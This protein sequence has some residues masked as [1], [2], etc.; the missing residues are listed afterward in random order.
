MPRLRSS[1]P[2]DRYG[3]RR[4]HRQGLGRPDRQAGTISPG[5]H[6]GGLV[7]CVLARRPASRE[8]KLRSV[9]T[10]TTTA[11]ASSQARVLALRLEGSSR[12]ISIFIRGDG[13]GGAVKGE[14]GASNPTQPRRQ[15]CE[16]VRRDSRAQE[17]RPTSSTLPGLPYEDTTPLRGE[18]RDRKWLAVAGLFLSWPG[19]RSPSSSTGT[20]TTSRGGGGFGCE[21]SRSRR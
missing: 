9:S 19:S 3:R 20:R 12:P 6:G 21:Q 13:C 11:E 18:R 4:R 15:T 10:H 14:S 17:G 16:S 5:S 1:H 7:T 8:R 2:P